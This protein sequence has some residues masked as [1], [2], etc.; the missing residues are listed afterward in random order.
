[1]LKVIDLLYGKNSLERKVEI[2][3][4]KPGNFLNI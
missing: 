3:I 1:M 2:N 4:N